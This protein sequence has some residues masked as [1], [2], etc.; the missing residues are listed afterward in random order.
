MPRLLLA[1]ALTY[2]HRS[3]EDT[4]RVI[5]FRRG[6]PQDVSWTDYEFLLARGG[7]VDPD[8]EIDFCPPKMLRAARPGTE[9][10]VVRTG[11][12]GDVL[13]VTIALREAA[14]A[15]PKLQFAYAT[16]RQY[17]PLMRDCHFLSRATALE[18]LR[19]RFPYGIDLRGYSERFGNERHFRIDVFSKYLAGR[20]AS[21]YRYPIQRRPE[22]EERGI[23]MLGGRDERPIL[24]LVLKAASQTAREWSLPYLAR[25]ALMAQR[26][27]WRSVLLDVNR[28]EMTPDMAAAGTINMTGRVDVQGLICLLQALDVLVAPDTGTLHLGEALEVPSVAIMTTVEPD[29]RLR[30]YRWT[31]ALWAGLPCSPCYHQVC[32]WPDPKPCALAVTPE[33]VWRE[34]EYVYEHEPPWTLEPAMTPAP[35]HFPRRS[36]LKQVMRVAIPEMAVA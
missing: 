18:D 24:G 3:H 32:Q 25:L 4:T 6:I 29:A 16:S 34:V 15:W 17:L 10:P 27:G 2:L 23:E 7:F 11:G 31:R 21:D 35:V 14:L 5:G 20:E 28:A 12:M 9:I 22:E 13:M 33:T 30:H 36:P 1:Q 26:A 8:R 19:G